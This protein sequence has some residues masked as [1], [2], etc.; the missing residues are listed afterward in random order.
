MNTKWWRCLAVDDDG[1]EC[2]TLCD[3]SEDTCWR[4]GATRS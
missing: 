1:E 2:G 4:C 3:V